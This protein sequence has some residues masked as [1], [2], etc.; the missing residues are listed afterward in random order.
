MVVLCEHVVII[1]PNLWP[2]DIKK[3]QFGN[4]VL[5]VIQNGIFLASATANVIICDCIL[6]MCN[7]QFINKSIFIFL[8][9]LLLFF[10]LTFCIFENSF[11]S[12]L[13]GNDFQNELSPLSTYS[14]LFGVSLSSR[15]TDLGDLWNCGKI[16]LNSE[17]VIRHLFYD[18]RIR[19]LVNK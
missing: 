6:W 5:T 1:K 16:V 8:V 9:L 15:H 12:S 7:M 13:W 3:G 17:S 4:V 10:Y 11:V 14:F 18:W 19:I 2:K